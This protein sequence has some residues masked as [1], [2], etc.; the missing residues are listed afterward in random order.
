MTDLYDKLKCAIHSVVVRFN[1]FD[2]DR[3]TNII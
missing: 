3:P 2:Y 1:T